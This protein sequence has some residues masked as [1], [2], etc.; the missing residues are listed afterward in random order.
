MLRNL[1]DFSL[2]V[3]FCFARTGGRGKQNYKSSFPLSVRVSASPAKR[4]VYTDPPTGGEV[5][6]NGNITPSG[7]RLQ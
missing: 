5:S 6:W 4:G 1:D 2:G 7:A 3:F